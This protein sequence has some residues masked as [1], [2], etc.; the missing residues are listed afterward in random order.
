MAL[1]EAVQRG[2]IVRNPVVLTQP[3]RPARRRARPGW[4]LDEAQR[5]LVAT[6]D[7]RLGPAFHLALVTGLRRG[8]LLGLQ[9]A[10]LDLDHH[11]LHVTQQ[12][13][14]EGGRPRI[15]DLK[16]S[17][18]ERIVTFGPSA[19]VVLADHAQR[20]RYERG[21]AAWSETGLVF[22]T[23][24]GGWIDPSTFGRHMRELSEGARVPAITPRG[25]RHTAQ[26]LGRVVVGDDKVMQER[27]GH[28]D[29]GV[30]LNTYTHTVDEHHRE[31]GLRIDALLT[32][33]PRNGRASS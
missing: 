3:P 26:S 17:A 14:V 9:W 25:L 4:T 2:R 16:T 11:E 22:T 19:A 13:A 30:T 21:I 32:P 6:A 10:D 5:F 8:E 12:L 31:A 27:L 1:D 28:T 20:Q 7:H 24:L 15:K 29:I 18:S 33:E 23:P